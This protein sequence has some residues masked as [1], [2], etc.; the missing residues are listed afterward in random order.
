MYP[1]RHMHLIDKAKYDSPSVSSTV[2]GYDEGYH[3]I[4][5]TSSNT[6]YYST[7]S[8]NWYTTNLGQLY[9][10]TKTVY[11]KAVGDSN[12][13][14][15]DVV[16]ATVTIYNPTLYCGATELLRG[17]TTTASLDSYAGVNSISYATNSSAATANLIAGTSNASV[18]ASGVYYGNVIVTS[19]INYS[20][21][22]ISRTC[23]LT[24][25]TGVA[26]IDTVAVD[27]A[28]IQSAVD[29]I[30]TSGTV[31]LIDNTTERATI[32]DGKTININFNA[33]KVT[34]GLAANGTNTKMTLNGGT[35]DT[36]IECNNGN[37][38]SASGTSSVIIKSGNY[39]CPTS[40]D[41]SPSENANLTISGGSFSGKYHAIHVQSGSPVINISA[42]DFT[43]AEYDA[44][45]FAG[46]SNVTIS[47][48]TFTGYNHGIYLEGTPTV[49]INNGTFEGQNYTG[50]SAKDNSH[51]TINAGT[52]NGSG[53]GLYLVGNSI[54]NISAGTFNSGSN[55]ADISGNA[56]VTITGGTFTTTKY[57]A[58]RVATTAV[59]SIS[60]G[61]FNGNTNGIIVED[62]SSATIS[63]GI[64]QTTKAN[65]IYVND[66]ATASVTGGT[67]KGVTVAAYV[68]TD[69]NTSFHGGTYTCSGTFTVGSLDSSDAFH[70]AGDGTMSIKKVTASNCYDGL[71]C[72]NGTID[73]H[74]G[75]ITNYRTGAY[76]W[77]TGTIKLRKG[78]FNY[79]GNKYGFAGGSDVETTTNSSNCTVKTN[80]KSDS[81]TYGAKFVVCETVFNKVSFS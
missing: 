49:V 45:K 40:T 67:F 16:S 23:S 50:I 60:G 35:S 70:N 63:G 78:T 29:N 31:N 12:H 1:Q 57:S 66:H 54:V 81:S 28:T 51:I 5:V 32:S 4:N 76:L 11:V 38:I 22:S 17:H 20:N 46:S 58:V 44:V 72:K 75:T 56:N 73:F 43:S 14:D 52:F 10:G 74:S 27:Y 7:D 26:R 59:V 48:G 19:T 36:Q 3:Y 24:V 80:N 18:A 42:G 15:S 2:W 64:F 8:V 71:S 41:I 68:K 13:Y 9:A 69:Q 53:D 25:K 6:L 62:N 30:S 55:C 37:S 34:G 77:G 47:G 61:T 33:Y 65:G 79:G 39:I 21:N